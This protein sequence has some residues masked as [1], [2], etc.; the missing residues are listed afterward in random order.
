MQ[1]I[2]RELNASAFKAAGEFLKPEQITRLKQIALHQVRGAQA[3]SDP[4]V[5]KKLNITDAQKSEIQ[6]ISA[7]VRC[8]RCARSSRRTRTTARRP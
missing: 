5:A 1:E 8:R 4:E 3:F 2:N 6:E 7:G